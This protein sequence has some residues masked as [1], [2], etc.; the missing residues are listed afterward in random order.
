MTGY[1]H[2]YEKAQSLSKQMI[3]C[4]FNNTSFTLSL[5]WQE[6]LSEA[7]C[8]IFFLSLIWR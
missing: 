8:Y 7:S 3:S 2:Y 1:Y 5:K 4:F 6:D